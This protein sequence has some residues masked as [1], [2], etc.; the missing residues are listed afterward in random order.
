VDA[1]L[2]QLQGKAKRV[3]ATELISLLTDFYREKLAL[4]NRHAE[5]AKVVP[6]Y[7]FNNTYQYVVARE[8]AQLAWLREALRELEATLPDTVEA[9]RVPEG[10]TRDGVQLEVARDDA[11]TADEFVARWRPRVE[12]M[13]HARHGR[14]LSVILG[15]TIEHKRFFDQ[16]VE[17]RLDVLG[18]RPESFSTGGGVLPARWVE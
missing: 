1:G 17:G 14:M 16:I 6:G 3:K 15:E 9:L 2:H 12:A 11:R 10:R 18:R 5:G 8:D 13:T 7:E 4:R